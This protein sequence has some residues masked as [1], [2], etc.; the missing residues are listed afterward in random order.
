M[1]TRVAL[2]YYVL[3]SFLCRAAPFISL[4]SFYSICFQWWEHFVSQIR[5]QIQKATTVKVSSHVQLISLFRA[6]PFA[7]LP[8]F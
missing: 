5:T 3:V 7:P 8:L 6:T 1:T 2:S 4:H